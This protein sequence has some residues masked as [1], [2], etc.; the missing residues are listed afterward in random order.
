MSFI[1]DALKKSESERQRQ[2]GP[3]F[4]TI[5]GGGQRKSLPG[6]AL[7]LAALLLINIVVVLIVALWPDNEPDNSSA[8][9][10]TVSNPPS[11]TQPATLPAQSEARG[12]PEVRSLAQE[13]EKSN[14]NTSTSVMATAHRSAAAPATASSGGSVVY[15]TSNPYVSSSDLP[16]L[17]DLH[18]QGLLSIPNLHMDIHVYG[19]TESDRFVFINMRKYAK[20]DAL[21]E[22][23]VVED[24]LQD[25]VV[26]S[27]RGLRFFLPRD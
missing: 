7:A 24:I 23:P 21:K 11:R 8:A 19:E 4:V 26:L 25:G 16:T 12:R 13:V 14:D 20:G 17:A 22:G 2:T 18:S 3:G 5:A 9:Q 6:W 1:L 10:G 27:E 15:Q